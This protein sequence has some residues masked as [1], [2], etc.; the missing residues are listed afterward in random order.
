MPM[1]LAGSKGSAAG[2][3]ESE[4]APAGH[5]LPGAG[6]VILREQTGPKVQAATWGEAG[7]VAMLGAGL[8]AGYLG[9]AVPI[10][11]CTPRLLSWA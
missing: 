6:V 5:P 9:C 11:L 4:W 2:P 3:G 8:A 10:W 7:E 1:W